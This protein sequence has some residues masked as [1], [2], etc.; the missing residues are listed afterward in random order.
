M[1]Y[2]GPYTEKSVSVNQKYTP[3]QKDINKNEWKMGKKK[4]KKIPKKMKRREKTC[5][6]WT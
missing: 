5:L 6:N 3:L 4:I 2:L 1:K